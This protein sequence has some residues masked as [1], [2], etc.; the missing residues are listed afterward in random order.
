MKSLE[1]ELEELTGA[2]HEEAPGDAVYPYMVFSA[3]R[4]SEDEGKQ[5]YTLEANVWDQNPYYS[6]AEGMM[7]ALEKKLHRCNFQTEG[8]LIR[9]F[10]GSRQN[11]PDPDR[12]VRRVREQ[13]EMQVYERE[14]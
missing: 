7:D 1:K 11:V 6:R 8:F 13:F 14:D 12:S 9:I 4:L 10:K 5:L 2:Y 3:K